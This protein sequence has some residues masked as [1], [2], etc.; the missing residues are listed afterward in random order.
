MVAYALIAPQS[1]AR[2]RVLL[3]LAFALT[4]AESVVLLVST[5]ATLFR[6]MGTVQ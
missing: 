1:L 2:R 6:A 4:V 5:Y 3:L